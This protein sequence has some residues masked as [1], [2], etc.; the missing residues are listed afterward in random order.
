MEKKTLFNLTT[1]PFS[2]LPPPMNH[3]QA[4]RGNSY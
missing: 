4:K 1:K 3:L 2:P